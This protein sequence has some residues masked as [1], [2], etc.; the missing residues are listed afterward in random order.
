MIPYL[1]FEPFLSR[2][3][4]SADCPGGAVLHRRGHGGGGRRRL[5]GRRHRGRRRRFGL[6]CLNKIWKVGL[7]RWPSSFTLKLKLPNIRTDLPWNFKAVETRNKSFCES[8]TYQMQNSYLHI[9]NLPTYMLSTNC[10]QSILPTILL[11]FVMNQYYVD[12]IN[13]N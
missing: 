5:R 8:F 3:C 1:K 9:I 10:C 12:T 4:V 11:A 2:A 7:P 6:G 13:I